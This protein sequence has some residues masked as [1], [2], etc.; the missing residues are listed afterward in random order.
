MP[1]TCSVVDCTVRGTRGSGIKMY[2]F[3]KYPP[4]RGQAWIRAINS[5][6]N[7]KHTNTINILIGSTLDGQI[8][9][10][11]DAWVGIVYDVKLTKEC[12]HECNILDHLLPNDVVLADR[13]FMQTFL[14]C[15]V[16]N[17]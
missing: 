4:Y 11:S 5:N 17:L 9:F 12:K 16:C 13:G 6:S 14:L 7:Y 2:K 10:L 8:W 1:S 15:V 3:P